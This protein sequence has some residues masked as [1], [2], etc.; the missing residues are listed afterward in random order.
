LQFFQHYV[1]K[2]KSAALAA[3]VCF[4]SILRMK[5]VAF[6][7]YCARDGVIQ[8]P[9]AQFRGWKGLSL[10]C[11]VGSRLAMT[12]FFV[13]GL[14]SPA[15]A[16]QRNCGTIVVPPGVGIGPG[17][18]VTSFNP[19]LVDSEYNAEAA[20][21]LFMPLIWI[22]RF[23]T[24]D[25]SR[26]IASAVTS[27]DDGKMYDVTLRDWHWSDGV[28][29]TTKDVV[30]TYNLIKALGTTYP[31]YGSGGM[32][33]IIASIKVVD[34]THFFVTLKKPV[35]PD[36]FILNGLA[37]LQP[38]PAHVWGQYT[39]DQIYQAQSSPAF[40]TVDDGPLKID[41]LVVGVDAEFVPNPHYEG[42]KM[43]FDRFIMKFMNAEGQELQAVESGDLDMS[44]LPFALWNA[45]QNLPGLHVVSLPPTYSW[46]ELIPNMANPASKYFADVRVRQAVADA[47]SQQRM[48]G[49][50]MH[51]QGV[52]VRGP[53]PPVPAT[54][55]SPAAKAGDY[56]VGY[57]PDKAKA[58]LAAAGFTAGADGIL[59]KDGERLSFTLLIP[60]GQNMRIEMAES[61]QQDLRAVG[62]EMKVHQVEFNQ[63]MAQMTGQPLAWE[64]IL[65]ATDIAAFP[66]G[67]GNFATG[68]FYNNNG[69]ANKA[70]D[71]DIVAS[72]DK[73][74]L[75]GLF[76]Y[77]DFASEQEPV[78]FLPN[79]KYSVLVR[80]G[81]QGVEDFMNPLGAWAPDQLYCTATN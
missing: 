32:P 11:G 33:D 80:N 51:G 13:L 48:I 58:L 31:G 38:F 44:N 45:A 26:S 63:I 41:K 69:Y 14:M 28:K 62:I 74:G 37:Q 22:N 56:A 6:R 43:H 36:W 8:G 72:T 70:M 78:I 7:H 34:D 47:I 55:L 15:A 4:G 17:S 16:D 23:H 21:L 61:M 49:L 52:E 67:E 57:D 76:A 75:A 25:F 19:L 66:S 79:E 12:M 64:A 65:I 18:D 77:Q 54:F 29:V 60:A 59:Q 81:L 27:P 2:F 68:A 42:P 1:E 46:H 24:I 9:A 5:V 10:D 35:N 50:A 30:Y 20:N 40:F 73:P 3:V 39:T 53:V 71:A